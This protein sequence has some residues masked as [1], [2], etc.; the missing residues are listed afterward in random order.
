MLLRKGIT[1]IGITSDF[2]TF[3]RYI[4][5]Q[6]CLEVGYLPPSLSPAFTFP[7]LSVT[8]YTSSSSSL[9]S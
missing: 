5:M 2:L 7:A 9:A 3:S 8:E 1:Y 6:Y 4:E